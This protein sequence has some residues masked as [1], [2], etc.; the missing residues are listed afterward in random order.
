M[1]NNIVLASCDQNYYDLY[2]STFEQSLS[3]LNQP[4]RIEMCDADPPSNWVDAKPGHIIG[5]KK[6]WYACARYLILP[7]MIEEHGGVFVSDI[8]VF[9]FKS[10]PFPDTKIGLV[11]TSPK[12]HR[13]EW[14]QRGMH[15]MAGFF[16][17]QDIDI[18]VQIRNK[19]NELPKRWFV[20]QIAIHE[21]IKH[22]KS[23]T[24]FRKPPT[25]PE[26]ITNE[27]FALVPRGKNKVSLKTKFVKEQ[28]L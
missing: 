15:V 23:R 26:K 4:Y 21:V 12:N 10:I 19:I 17:C 24:Y 28:L 14:E 27:D 2:G 8:D 22:E 6:T 1:K 3:I 20:D 9:F 5:M 18:A 7:E 11:K 13:S 25:S 16:Y